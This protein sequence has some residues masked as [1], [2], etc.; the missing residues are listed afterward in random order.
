MKTFKD[1][2]I[3]ASNWFTHKENAACAGTRENMLEGR[4]RISIRTMKNSPDK[5]LINKREVNES[6][7]LVSVFTEAH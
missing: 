1:T 3:R 5:I 2:Q 7:E 4:V 6:A